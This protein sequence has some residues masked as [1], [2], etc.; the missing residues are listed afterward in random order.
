MGSPERLPSGTPPLQPG[1]A[2]PRPSSANQGRNRR[3]TPRGPAAG[4]ESRPSR[5]EP[6]RH[7][8]T[9]PGS[10]AVPAGPRTR[11]SGET[12]LTLSKPGEACVP[13]LGTQLRGT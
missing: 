5:S 3:P 8:A 6:G 7:R 13:R 1:A 4:K 9:V 10:K 2:L 11:D 12:A